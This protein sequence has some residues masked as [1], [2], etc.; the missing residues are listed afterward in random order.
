MG[1]VTPAGRFV[2][3]DFRSLYLLATR[4]VGK[5]A[6]TGRIDLFDTRD[7]SGP[8]LGDTNEHGWALTAAWRYP[9]S[10]LLDVRVEAMNIESDRPGRTLAGEAAQ[11][12][13]TVLQSSLR[14]SF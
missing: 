10:K 5:S 7:R 6:F 8:S 4:D 9:L 2:D 1:F 13:Q 3:M 14:L 11:Q 12:S